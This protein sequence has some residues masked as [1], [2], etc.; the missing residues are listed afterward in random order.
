MWSTAMF[1]PEDAPAP[2]ATEW[3]FDHPIVRM[4]ESAAPKLGKNSSLVTMEVDVPKNA[5]GVLYALAG[6][7]GGVTCYVMDGYLNYEFNLFEI[8]RTKVRSKNKLPVGKVKIE[9]ESKLKAGIGGPMDITLRVN[10]EVVG[11]GLV[12]AAMSL[13]FTSNATF[14]I[15]IDTDSPVALDYYDQAPFPFTGTIGKT[16]I[17]YLNK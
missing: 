16:T 10:G 4:P 7:S 11:H 1:H 2:K 13:H 9:V 5:H 12:P 6:F 15:G 3:T 14:D 8:Q 17:R